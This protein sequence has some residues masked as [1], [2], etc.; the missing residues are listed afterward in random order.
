MLQKILADG[1]GQF[2]D[3]VK[4]FTESTGWS[5]RFVLAKA[6][7]RPGGRFNQSG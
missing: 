2:R 6:W 1:L 5:H 3:Q 4:L 7:F